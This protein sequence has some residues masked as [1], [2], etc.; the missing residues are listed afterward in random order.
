MTEEH[1][2]PLPGFVTDAEDILHDFDEI[3]RANDGILT[4]DKIMMIK[5]AIEI[6]GAH[7]T[8]ERLAENHRVSLDD[9][10]DIISQMK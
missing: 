3:D 8:P 2:R 9:V 6:A 7:V 1:K 5:L 4:D 10:K